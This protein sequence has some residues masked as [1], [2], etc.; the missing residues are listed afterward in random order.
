MDHTLDN[1]EIK[2]NDVHNINRDKTSLDTETKQRAN[3]FSCFE[4]GYIK[5]VLQSKESNGTL[6]NTDKNSLVSDYDKAFMIVNGEKY[7]PDSEA[8]TLVGIAGD[9]EDKHEKDDYDT[10]SDSVETLAEDSP[11]DL[12]QEKLSSAYLPQSCLTKASTKRE[13]PSDLVDLQ[14]FAVIDLDED[15][16]STANHEDIAEKGF[17]NNMSASRPESLSLPRPLQYAE[18]NRSATDPQKTSN[19]R[20]RILNG[21]GGSSL[22]GHKRTRSEAIDIQGVRARGDLG[23]GDDMLSKSLPHG[24]IMR[25]GELIEFVADDLQEK[26]KRSSPM[27]RGEYTTFGIT[28]IVLYVYNFMCNF[29]LFNHLKF[30][31]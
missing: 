10:H 11:H 24:T 6:K 1:V 7:S 30:S 20:S 16:S 27:S 5:D 26:I 22:E 17:L 2:Q 23:H 29:L 21:I 13:I 4:N 31:H 25:K 15:I 14:R 19:S 9:K 12:S 28:C 8:N 3:T 18:R